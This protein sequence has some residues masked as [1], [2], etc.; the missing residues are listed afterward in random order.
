MNREKRNTHR[1]LV[2]QP[3]GRWPLGRPRCRCVDIKMNLRQDGLVCTG[4]I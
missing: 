3:E 4:L 1:F 2:G